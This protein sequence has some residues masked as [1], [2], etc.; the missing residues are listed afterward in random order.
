MHDGDDDDTVGKGGDDA[1]DGEG[2]KKHG[3]G[4]GVRG[5]RK[6]EGE[7]ERRLDVSDIILPILIPPLVTV[8]L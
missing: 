7:G 6:G 3:V 1:K 2:E 5:G 4:V 8:L